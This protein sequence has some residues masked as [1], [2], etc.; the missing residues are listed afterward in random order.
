MGININSFGKFMNPKTYKTCKNQWSATGNGRTRRMRL[1]SLS[2]VDP[3][4][5]AKT[6]VAG[7]G[8][9]GGGGD[10]LPQKERSVCK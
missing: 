7:G 9:D 2:T 3:T 4:K 6:G 8:D 5:K 10:A 1:M